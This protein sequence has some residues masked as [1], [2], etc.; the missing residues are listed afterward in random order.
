GITPLEA[1]S[2]DPQQRL[3]LETTWEALEAAGQSPARL[4]G[5]RTGVFVGISGS[6]YGQIRMKTGDPSA[7]D[8]YAG[9]GTALSVAAGRISYF[10]GLQGPCLAVDTAC[11]S[12]L[13]ALHLA[14]QHLRL[15]E[16]DLAIVGGVN[17]VL[18]ADGTVYF[19]KLR[20]LSPTGRCRTFD[21]GADGYVRGEGCGVVVLARLSDA[22]AGRDPI[23]AVVRG[24]AVNQDGRSAGLT[25]PNGPA[26]EAVIRAALGTVPPHLVGYVEAH[27]TGTPLGDPIETGA[28]G[29]VYSRGRSR[30]HPLAIGSVKTNFG[31]LEPAAGVAG[32]IKTVLALAKRTIPSHLHLRR[33]NPMISLD[34]VPAFIPSTATP[35]LPIEGRRLAGVSSFGFSGTNA[36]VILEEAP[37]IRREPG[38]SGSPFHVRGR[39]CALRLLALSA[40]TPAALA[41]LAGRFAAWFSANPDVPLA[42][43]SHTLLAGRSHFAHRLALVVDSAVEAGERLAARASGRAEGDAGK[44][45]GAES[46]RLHEL[47]RRYERGEEIDPK[48][49]GLA[50]PWKI[51]LPTY[52]FQRKR[53]WSLPEPVRSPRPTETRTSD[54]LYRLDWAA[55]PLA[56]GAPAS[57]TGEWLVIADR[58][59][60]GKRLAALLEEH[61]G[62]C[63]VVAPG[64]ELPLEGRERVLSGVVHLSCLDIP[65]SRATTLPSLEESRRLGP[66]SALAVARW[67]AAGNGEEAGGPPRLWL[68]TRGAQAVKEGEGPLAIGAATVWGLGRAVYAERPDLRGALVDL[69]SQPSPGEAERLLDE[70]LRGDGEDQVAF[71]GGTRLVARLRRAPLD[72][73]GTPGELA[74][75]PDATYLVTGGTGGLGLFVARWMVGRG[76]RHL[77]LLARRA[78][79]PEAREA[80]LALER[81]GARVVTTACD[82][83]RRDDLARVLGELRRS[84]PP[85]AGVVHAAGVIEDAFLAGQSPESLARV[86]APKV[87]GAWNLDEATRDLPLEFFVLFSSASSILGHAGQANYAAANSFLDALA[88]DRR[89]RGLPALAIQWGPW[90]E[91]GMAARVD[92]SLSRLREARGI[93]LTEPEAGLAIL[94]R[95]IL[96]RRTSVAVLAVDWGKFLS[97]GASGETSRA[98]LELAPATLGPGSPP[99]VPPA[100][101]HGYLREVLAETLGTPSEDLS[102]GANLMDL[103]ADSLM[104]MELLRRLKKDLGIALYPREFYERPTLGAFA[105]Y[106]A[107]ELDRESGGAPGRATQAARKLRP[108]VFLLSSPRAG[109]TLLR[110][111]LAGHPRLFCPPELHLLPFSGMKERRQALGPSHLDEGLVRAMMELRGEG[112][113]TCR[114]LVGEL[115]L[116]DAPVEEVYA[117]LQELASPRLL[118]DKSPTYAAHPGALRR[119]EELFGEARYVLLARHPSAVIESFVR[120]RMD[121]LMGAGSGD[122]REVA[123]QVWARSYGGALD[124]FDLLGPGRS[125]VLRYEDLVRDPAVVMARLSEFLGVEFDEALLLPYQG[126]RMTDGLSSGSLG[127][128]DPNFLEHDR[129]EPGLADAWRKTCNPASLGERT[130]ELA[131]RLG[132]DLP[133]EAG[134]SAITTSAAPT[135]RERFVEVRSLR[136]CLLSWG[137][138]DVPDVLCFHGALEHAAVW[139]EVASRLA[140]RGLSVAAPDQRGHGLSEHVGRGGSYHLLDFVADLDALLGRLTSRPVVLVGHSMGAAVAALQAAARPDRVRAL[141]LVEPVLG[142]PGAAEDPIATLAA[143]LDHLERPAEHALL[144]DLAAAAARLR[145]AS[146]ALSQERALALARR[147]TL[148]K[149]GGLVWRHD[150]RLTSRA[151]LVWE[152]GTG[153]GASG[154]LALAALGR[155][156]ARV[157][158][159]CGEESPA[160]RDPRLR[161]PG[162][163]APVVLLPGGHDVHVASPAAL[164]DLIAGLA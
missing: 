82:V 136:L 22:I 47:A 150:P 147:I 154:A 85:L 55:S 40:R 54:P 102:S 164:A 152:G 109:S 103:G 132:Y 79:A 160:A 151:G 2:M 155:I 88:H 163:A 143:H 118:V 157:A 63:H 104:V 17:A 120:V 124:F 114:A 101:L 66:E 112:A 18:S 41:E 70:L 153:P 51:A 95:A 77:A 142:P 6:D 4:A 117:T 96:A 64:A 99:R 89:S 72:L 125:H 94:E 92:P 161:D 81:S 86:L 68:V 83:S 111:M 26:Q 90:A 32:L 100:D 43:V 12:S 140:A 3:L 48:E 29:A 50:E 113:Q 33:L 97:S 122:P 74:L 128:G 9:T 11:S 148:E 162:H 159:V 115:A 57:A 27:G 62:T 134:G 13:V 30:E 76:A 146:P 69:D 145:V 60:V 53:Y 59:G 45:E 149:D 28:L 139:E 119:V 16:C 65:D 87:E 23:L 38:V 15:G 37:E 42:D 34:R 5:S 133:P 107:R 84:M 156:R 141:V 105:E 137:P 80:I 116:R 108:A 49:L 127:I 21:A 67:L 131:R 75:R 61:G 20:A 91:A 8:A 24:T 129:I 110:V 1:A 25:A 93:A 98:L 44:E 14:C 135:V 144:H 10:L 106:L 39:A 123:E 126:N 36:H 52:P 19:S 31:H 58:S 56:V 138:E 46:A 7:I 73:A 78:P 35:W 121:R 71:R 158:V 130:R